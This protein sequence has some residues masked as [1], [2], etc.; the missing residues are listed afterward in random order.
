M[1]GTKA[2]KAC[3]KACMG[4]PSV[5]RE[6]VREGRLC[7]SEMDKLMASVKFLEEKLRPFVANVPKSDDASEEPCCFKSEVG[8]VLNSETNRLKHVNSILTD[9]LDSLQF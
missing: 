6:I 2:E 8:K 1:L 3:E 4:T 9:L 7:L 5:E